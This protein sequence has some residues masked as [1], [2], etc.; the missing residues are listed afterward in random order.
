MIP[1][2][3]SGCSHECVPGRHTE[4]SRK[5][6]GW[7]PLPAKDCACSVHYVPATNWPAQP[8]PKWLALS[9]F[10]P[11]ATP[12]WHNCG[13]H[14]LVGDLWLF[15]SCWNHEK[16][17]W[18]LNCTWSTTEIFP[19][20]QSQANTKRGQFLSTAGKGAHVPCTTARSV[21]I[22]ARNASSCCR[23]LKM[24]M[25]LARRPEAS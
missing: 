3:A 15:R 14:R 19:S 22:K 20:A 9:Y 25:L 18:Q 23:L 10:L 17:R 24:L 4:R 11:K 7:W 13:Q 1:R 16:L 8:S 2:P 12:A 6:L 5:I 21:A